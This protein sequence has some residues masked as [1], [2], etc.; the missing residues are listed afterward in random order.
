[1][2]DEFLSDD[3]LIV[4][5]E[6]RKFEREDTYAQYKGMFEKGRLIVLIDEASASVLNVFMQF[7][8]GSWPHHGKKELGKDWSSAP[9]D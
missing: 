1:M 2:S 8:I 7:K 6:G 4:Y 5:T 9:C 3:K